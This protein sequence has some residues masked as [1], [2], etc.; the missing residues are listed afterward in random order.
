VKLRE[1]LDWLSALSGK[2]LNP[3]PLGHEPLEDAG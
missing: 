2:T 1:G 3:Y